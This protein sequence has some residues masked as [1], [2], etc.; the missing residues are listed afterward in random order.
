MAQ[1]VNIFE[2]HRQEK[3]QWQELKLKREEN[4]EQKLDDRDKRKEVFQNSLLD[5]LNR[6]SELEKEKLALDKRLLE[7]KERKRKN[8]DSDSD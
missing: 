8:R 3:K 1:F 7:R 2:E 4:R 5:I 6:S